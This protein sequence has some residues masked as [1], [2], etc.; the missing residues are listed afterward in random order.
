MTIKIF[1][2]QI[3]FAGRVVLEFGNGAEKVIVR[4]NFQG[5]VQGGGV[6]LQGGEYP[7]ISRADQEQ[8]LRLQAP[9][10][11][12]EDLGK[13]FST[14]RGWVEGELV[15]VDLKTLGQQF[16]PEMAHGREEI[17]Q[18]QLMAPD[19]SGLFLDLGHPDRILAGIETLEN[20]RVVI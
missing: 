18:P 19:V 20:L 6:L 14:V 1:L 17:R 9:D 16:L 10:V 7:V 4:A 11:L 13:C 5:Q 12:V 15:V 3:F 2:E 8:F